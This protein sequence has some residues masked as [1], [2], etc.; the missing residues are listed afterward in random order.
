MKITAAGTG[1]LPFKQ[2][3]ADADMT[4][5]AK[6]QKTCRDFES[7]LIKQMLTV[8]RESV[9]KDG[10]FSGGSAED[11]FRSLQDDELSKSLVDNGGFGFGD[12][13][14]RQLS[15]NMISA[16]GIKE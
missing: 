4:Q 14:Y 3:A 8:M 2:M 11:I 15:Q 12:M 1:P 6:L 5:E 16:S 7:V 9:P 10:L 13:L